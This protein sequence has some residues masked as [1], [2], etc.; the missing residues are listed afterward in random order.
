MIGGGQNCENYNCAQFNRKN[1]N[2][3]I[4]NFNNI[5]NLR[6]S[7]CTGTTKIYYGEECE[8]PEFD[9][10]IL[11]RNS[12]SEQSSLVSLV[13]GNLNQGYKMIFRGGTMQTLSTLSNKLIAYVS[14][15]N[16]II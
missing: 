4:I 11:L 13:V 15:V 2:F 8:E 10:E 14:A 1:N 5:D 16:K 3:E 7:K 9:S 12:S 6:Q